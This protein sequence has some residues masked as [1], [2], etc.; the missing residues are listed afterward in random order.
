MLT[1]VMFSGLRVTVTV[2]PHKYLLAGRVCMNLYLYLMA[3]P[4][5]VIHIMMVTTQQDH[6][7]AAL[8]SRLRL[9]ED[10]HYQQIIR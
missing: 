3:S 1:D 5:A 6:L 8:V 4:Y 10:K 7:V 9:E 2:T